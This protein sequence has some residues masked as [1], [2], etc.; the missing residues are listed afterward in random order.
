MPPL[1]HE[2]YLHVSSVI[3]DPVLNIRPLGIAQLLRTAGVQM[4]NTTVNCSVSRTRSLSA[5]WMAQGFWIR[6]H[7]LFPGECDC[8]YLTPSIADNTTL[9]PSTCKHSQCI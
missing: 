5:H 6:A 4:T 1:H 7:L 3:P 8:M 2:V 9:L